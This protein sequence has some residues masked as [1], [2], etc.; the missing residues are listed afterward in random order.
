MMAVEKCDRFVMNPLFGSGLP[1]RIGG[2]HG[3]QQ[4]SP[5]QYQYVA[6]NR[7]EPSVLRRSPLGNGSQ[8]N[9]DGSDSGSFVDDF[10]LHRAAQMGQAAILRQL[11]AQHYDVNQLDR[12]CWAPIHYASW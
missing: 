2:H 7:P 10:P 12:D 9:A 6:K 4:L 5:Q 1:Y 11:L 3:G 8:L